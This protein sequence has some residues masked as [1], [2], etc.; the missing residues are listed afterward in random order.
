MQIV[1]IKD[2]LYRGKSLYGQ[3]P[4][5]AQRQGDVGCKREL[6]LRIVHNGKEIN[7]HANRADFHIVEDTS[8]T[9]VHAPA[10]CELSIRIER[11]F[12]IMAKLTEFVIQGA[13]RSLIISGAAGIGKSYSLEKR[14]NQAI[15]RNEIGQFTILKGKIS[16]IALF[17]QLFEHRNKGDILVLDDID[18]IFQDETSLNLLKGALDTGDVRHLSWLT[19]SEWLAD[20]GV[21]QAFD[22]E[23]ACVFI[24]NLDFDRLMEKG[25]NLAPH[26]KALISRSIYLDL[27]IHTNKEIMTRIKQVVNNTTMLDV[28]GIDNEQKAMMMAWM[29]ANYENLRELSLRSI[30]KLAAFMKGDP[31]GW[32]DIAEAT[33]VR[34]NGFTVE[35]LDALVN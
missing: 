1:S 11:R 14:L 24:T 32:E 7:V 21:D 26:F 3:F 2:S 31:N 17:Q 15:D 22:F 30:L 12:D 18:V 27:G 28:H 34:N 9:P 4:L 8:K 23:G 35:A 29:E 20:Q 19:A 33:M 13:V 10:E 16:A 25:T 5:V 6:Y